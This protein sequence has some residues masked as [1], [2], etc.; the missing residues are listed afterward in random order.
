MGIRFGFDFKK[1]RNSG[2]QECQECPEFEKGHARAEIK[3]EAKRR[4]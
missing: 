4:S 3:R 2:I 1:L